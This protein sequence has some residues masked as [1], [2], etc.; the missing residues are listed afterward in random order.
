MIYEAQAKDN[1][2]EGIQI[3]YDKMPGTMFPLGVNSVTAI[4]TDKA[5][6]KATC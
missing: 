1:I 6:N 5:L 4:A 2:N 3:T